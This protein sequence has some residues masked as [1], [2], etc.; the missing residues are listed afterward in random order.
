M[1]LYMAHGTAFSVTLGICGLVLVIL[2]SFAVATGEPS[3]SFV[4]C[5][6]SLSSEI[7]ARLETELRQIA[8]LQNLKFDSEG[9]LRFDP[10][11]VSGGFSPRETTAHPRH[12]WSHCDRDRRR[13]QASRRRLCP[14]RSRKME[15]SVGK[16]ARSLCGFD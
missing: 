15:A 11:V 10:R 13:K 8:G 16:L 1:P 12:Q 3:Q 2:N 9:A 14:R 4:V 7:R 5:R 6:D